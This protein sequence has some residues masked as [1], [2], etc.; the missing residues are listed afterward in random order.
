MNAIEGGGRDDDEDNDRNC[1][2]REAETV[3]K[4]AFMLVLKLAI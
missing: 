3:R 4:F 1:M 2:E